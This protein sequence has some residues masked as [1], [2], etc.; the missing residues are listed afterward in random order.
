MAESK[1]AQRG[2][3]NYLRKQFERNAI[4]LF[5]KLLNLLIR[6]RFFVAKLI[7]REPTKYAST[8]ERKG[9][10]HEPTL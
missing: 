8:H 9:V 7:T 3:R 2:N 1:T 5:A 4:G 6:S 10:F